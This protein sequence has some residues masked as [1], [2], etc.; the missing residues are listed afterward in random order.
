[1]SGLFLNAQQ[2]SMF[3]QISIA[4]ESSDRQHS[5]A[6]GTVKNYVSRI[7]DKLHAN[8]RTELALLSRKWVRPE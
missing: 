8:T 7:M 2:K 4:A 5:L 1:M 6:E 3:V